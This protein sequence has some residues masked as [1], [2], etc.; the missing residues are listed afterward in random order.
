MTAQ[1]ILRD[2]TIADVSHVH[3]LVRGLAE[4]EKMLHRLTATEDDLRAALFGSAPPAFA[5][6]AEPP[7]AT[8]VGLALCYHT[9]SSFGCR[10]GIFL[11]DLF[12]EPAHRSRGIGLALLRHLAHRAVQEG[13]A[14]IEWRVLEWN[15]P[16]IA[17]YERLGAT[18]MVDWHVRQLQGDALAALARDASG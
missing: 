10:R 8:P 4:Y 9:F 11:E 1:V 5:I 2:A 7:G 18:R 12:V 14:D 6:L 16:A 15:A 13:C 17:F 3:R